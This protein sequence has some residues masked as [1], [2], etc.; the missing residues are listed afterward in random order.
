LPFLTLRR[1]IISEATYNGIYEKDL[2]DEEMAGV[3]ENRNVIGLLINQY[4]FIKNNDGKVVDKFRWDG[5]KFSPLKYSNY[6]GQRLGG[7]I[8]KPINDEQQALFD[9]LAN[10]DIKIKEIKG[11]AGSGKNYC[12]M[13]FA[14]SKIYKGGS[15]SKY[16]KIVLVR[17]NVEVKNSSPL[18]A[19]PSGINEK[20]LPYAMPA[21]DILGSKL[22]LNRMIADEKIELLH[23]GFARGRNFDNS[24]LIVDESENLTSAH[25][26]LLVSRVGKNS[27]ILFLGDQRQVDR[28]VF[29]K[30]SGL[31]RLNSR[32]SGNPLYGCVHLKSVERSE[33]AR[34]AELLQD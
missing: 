21:A 2:S 22:A 17:N 19:L 10:D 11:V 31:V 26:A 27:I 13:A 14:L 32:L 20:L 30:D 6:P 29:E 1:S 3:Y 24:I 28:V 23:L 8:V 18:G 5:E 12:A 33:T 34:L 7:K 25:V 16:Q 15:H 9:L 4:V